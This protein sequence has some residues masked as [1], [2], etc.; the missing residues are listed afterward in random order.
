MK[1]KNGFVTMKETYSLRFCALHYG[2]LICVLRE[3]VVHI[4][5]E[6][7]VVDEPGAHRVL[8]DQVVNFC[9]C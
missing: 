9:G 8:A 6:P 5:D 1:S 3:D 7:F 4:L 2:L